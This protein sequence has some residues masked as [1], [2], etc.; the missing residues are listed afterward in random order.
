M[1]GVTG[2]KPQIG[3]GDTEVMSSWRSNAGTHTHARLLALGSDTNKLVNMLLANDP[4]HRHAR[5]IG[6]SLH[7]LC[8]SHR[9][10]TIDARLFYPTRHKQCSACREIHCSQCGQRGTGVRPWNVRATLELARTEL[11][12]CEICETTG[13]LVDIDK[14]R[15]RAAGWTV[16]HRV[17]TFGEFKDAEGRSQGDSR[18]DTASHR[19][20]NSLDPGPPGRA[21]SCPPDGQT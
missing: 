13:H 21:R 15:S 6:Q 17:R 20:W 19:Q 7:S 4:R 1:T 2:R 8:R 11:Y 16:Y 14:A 9:L 10:C 18:W 12:L 3:E 5:Q